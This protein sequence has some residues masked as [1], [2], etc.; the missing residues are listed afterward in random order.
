MYP[1]YLFEYPNRQTLFPFYMKKNR[2][3]RLLRI[4]TTLLSFLTFP[5]AAVRKSLMGVSIG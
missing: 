5:Q 3:K 1:D 2:I 4:D